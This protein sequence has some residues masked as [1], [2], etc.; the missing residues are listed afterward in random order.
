[1]HGFGNIFLLWFHWVFALQYWRASLVL[2][3]FLLPP[4]PVDEDDSRDGLETLDDNEMTNLFMRI[5]NRDKA[6][7]DKKI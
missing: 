4:K 7:K 2:A 6:R 3:V 5:Y 1:V